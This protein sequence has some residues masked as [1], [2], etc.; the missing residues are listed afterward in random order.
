[1]Y[2]RLAAPL[3]ARVCASPACAAMSGMGD[4]SA[5]VRLCACCDFSGQL[6]GEVEARWDHRPE[7]LQETQAEAEWHSL[8][9][10]VESSFAL[11]EAS[12]LPPGLLDP[13]S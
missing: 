12:C 4:E 1:M 11:L 10:R 7:Q 13:Q 6:T 8:M 5:S 9:F 3:S 2:T